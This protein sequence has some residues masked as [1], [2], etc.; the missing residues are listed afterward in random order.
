MESG[1]PPFIDKM[2]Y[3]FPHAATDNPQ[4]M[5]FA[6]KMFALKP[7]WETVLQT[8][9]GMDHNIN[10]DQFRFSFIQINQDNCDYAIIATY[11]AISLH[12]SHR[13]EC[14]DFYKDGPYRKDR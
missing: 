11:P 1:E 6:K 5:N 12:S 9:Y 13:K 14:F 10:F 3:I 7:L 2:D 4:V 8:N